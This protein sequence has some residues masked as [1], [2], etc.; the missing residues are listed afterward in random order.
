MLDFD[1][2]FTPPKYG[3]LPVEIFIG[4][5]SCEF[6]ASNVLNDP[7]NELTDGILHVL[8]F[9]DAA[10]I[11]WWLE[12]DWHT[13]ELKPKLKS[14]NLEITFYCNHNQ[15]NFLK[16]Q[17]VLK[18]VVPTIKVCRCIASSLRKLIHDAGQSCYEDAKAWN[19]KF[20]DRK[21]EEIYSILRQLK[22]NK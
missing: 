4:Q 3:C 11:R 22:N 14:D 1:L 17:K 21:I 15:D 20:P 5:E 7:I 13:L 19:R 8:R 6:V 18:I 16:A 10:I 12:P 2:K 9:P